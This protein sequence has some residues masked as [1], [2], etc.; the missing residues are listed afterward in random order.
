MNKD[1]DDSKEDPDYTPAETEVE[2]EVVNPITQVI[3]ERRSK[4]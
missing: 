4:Q 3:I 2:D 1:S